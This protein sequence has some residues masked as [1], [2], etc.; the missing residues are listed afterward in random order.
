MERKTFLATAA[1]TAAALAACGKSDA[2]Q[3]ELVEP[4]SQFDYAAFAKLVDRP[5]DVR[6]LWDASHYQPG[7]LAGIKNA[8]NGYQFGYSID[9]KRIAQVLCLHGS[10]NAWAYDDS[11]W[12]KYQLGEMLQFK[13]PRGEVITTNVFSHAPAA[14][15][16]NDPN[17]PHGFYQLATIDA[18]QRRG[19][20]VLV[21]HTG[22]ADHARDIAASNGKMQAEDVLR[23]L[24]SHLIPG[25]IAVPS[26]AATIGLLQNRF[27]YAYTTA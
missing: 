24:L 11:M 13:D 3:L 19:L 17:D 10:A 8:Y 16:T 14:V 12:A 7:V 25:A 15:E 20:T 1:V 4:A 21:C 26:V 18:L 5:A 22:A 27:H 6:Q 23:D 2:N 9:P